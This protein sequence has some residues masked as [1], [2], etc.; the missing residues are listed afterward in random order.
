MKQDILS[1]HVYLISLQ[2]PS[3]RRPRGGDVKRPL[4]KNDCIDDS[5]QQKERERNRKKLEEKRAKII[6]GLGQKQVSWALI[7][8]KGCNIPSD[9]VT[10]IISGSIRKI[11]LSK[12]NMYPRTNGSFGSDSFACYPKRNLVKTFRERGSASQVLLLYRRRLYIRFRAQWMAKY[13][14]GQVVRKRLRKLHG[15]SGEPW[16]DRQLK[17]FEPIFDFY[18]SGNKIQRNEYLDLDFFL[19]ELEFFKVSL[20]NVKTQRTLKVP[21]RVWWRHF[22]WRKR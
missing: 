1:M 14:S 22:R 19:D 8:F 2:K 6:P 9:L 20:S 17:Y 15:T 11:R 7:S 16:M 3:I 4:L 12:L 10:I 18:Q 21:R 13:L 5:F